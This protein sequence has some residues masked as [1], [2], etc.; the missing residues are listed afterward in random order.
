M[1]GPDGRPKVDADD[2]RGDECGPC[3]I[4]EHD[5]CEGN[6]WLKPGPGPAIPL[7]RC[8]CVTCRLIRQAR[9]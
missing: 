6:H 1:N 5:Y 9:G 2:T 8:R 4:G 3:R 7:T